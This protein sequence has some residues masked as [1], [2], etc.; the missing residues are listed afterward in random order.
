[1]FF[2]Y[3]SNVISS[4]VITSTHPLQAAVNV[5][6][7]VKICFSSVD[8]SQMFTS[9]LTISVTPPYLLRS[10]VTNLLVQWIDFSSISLPFCLD[11]LVHVCFTFVYLPMLCELFPA[12]YCI[13]P[14]L[15]GAPGANCSVSTLSV[16]QLMTFLLHSTRVGASFVLCPSTWIISFDCSEVYWPLNCLRVPRSVYYVFVSVFCYTCV[17]GRARCHRWT[18]AA[19]CRWQGSEVNSGQSSPTSLSFVYCSSP[20][21]HGSNFFFISLL[22]RSRFPT[23]TDSHFILPVK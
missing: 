8:Q 16:N 3:K 11:S 1:M 15:G 20:G 10:T 5:W 17:T 21:Q 2:T 14:P 12:T 23:Y 4:K 7:P 18:G 6:I 22:F 13:H 9:K 19:A